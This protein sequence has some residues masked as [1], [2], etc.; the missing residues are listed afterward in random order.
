VPTGVLQELG[1]WKSEPMVRR[2]A[3]MSVKHLQ[4]YSD[5]LIFERGWTQR[6]RRNP[7]RPRHSFGHTKVR[8]KLYFI[9]EGSKNV[10]KLWWTH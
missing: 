10:G 5:Q 7:E 2:Y 6:S 8:P 9:K 1:G 4:P 3:H